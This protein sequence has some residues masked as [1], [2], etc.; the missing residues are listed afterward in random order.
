V[1]VDSTFM[2]SSTP[3][4]QLGTPGTTIAGRLRHS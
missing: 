1:L 2:V 3:P 4:A